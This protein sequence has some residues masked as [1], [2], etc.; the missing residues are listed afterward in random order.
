MKV[1]FFIGSLNGIGGVERAAINL[2]NGLSEFENIDITLVIFDKFSNPYFELNKN[3]KV[4][5]L[6]V[7]NYKKEYISILLKLNQLLKNNIDIFLTVETMSLVFAFLPWLLNRKKTKLV[8]WEHFN[9]RNNNG[10]KSRDFFRV[11]AA[12]Y[13][14]LIVLLTKR[15]KEEWHSRLSVRAKII[16]IYNINQFNLSENLYNL[17]S[18][19]IISLGRYTKVKGFDRLIKIWTLFQQ[20][21][22]CPQWNLNIVGYGEEKE[23]LEAM[24]SELGTSNI[25]LISTDNV[26]DIYKSSSFFCMSS[27]FE[28]LPMVLMEAQSFGLP[29]ISFDIFTGPSEILINDSGIIINDDNLMQYTDA[30]YKLISNQSLRKVMS[31]K[32]FTA[33]KRF[34][35]DSIISEWVI[36]L[37]N[38]N[39]IN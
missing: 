39:K 29:A 37:N 17:N 7:S 8:V 12:R 35:K 2:L 3:I 32:A 28:G 4:V 38:L 18:T 16:H 36:Q 19:N 9:F 20:K 1:L 24:I 27:Y 5:S 25:S 33:S 22:N 31:D 13:A 10:K 14:D 15:D 23:K 21:Y 26:A 11:L 30:I 34:S 6:N